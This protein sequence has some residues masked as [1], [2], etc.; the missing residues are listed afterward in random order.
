M[1]KKLPLSI[2]EIVAYSILGL[3]GIWGLVYVALGVSCEFISYKSALSETN[4]SFGDLGFLNQGLIILAVATVASVIILLI[5]A[6]TSDRDFEKAQRRAARLAKEP[7]ATETQ[8]VD[9]EA[10]PVTEENKQSNYL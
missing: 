9:A 4:K 2:F 6:K 8:V 3:L 1:K 10:T 7:A 5:N